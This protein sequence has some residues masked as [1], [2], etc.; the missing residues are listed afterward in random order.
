MPVEGHVLGEAD[1]AG[2]PVEQVVQAGA[3][4]TPAEG[5]TVGWWRWWRRQQQARADVDEVRPKLAVQKTV[6]PQPGQKWR[7]TPPSSPDEAY[8]RV[9][10]AATPEDRYSPSRP[11]SGAVRMLRRGTKAHVWI[12]KPEV[13]R[14]DRQA[15][16]PAR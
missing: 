11:P 10:A 2:P 14:H 5:V 15:Q 6:A 3:C 13:R 12:S 8:V 7:T 9:A 4:T 16:V 1:A